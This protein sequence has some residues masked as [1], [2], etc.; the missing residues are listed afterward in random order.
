MTFSEFI[1][2]AKQAETSPV[3]SEH[4]YLQV[5]LVSVLS[6]RV[7]LSLS[8]LRGWACLCLI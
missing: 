3:E 7:G 5:C 8:Y 4:Y 6:E 2:K 1:E